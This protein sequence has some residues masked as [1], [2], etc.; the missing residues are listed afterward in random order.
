MRQLLVWS[1]GSPMTWDNHGVLISD[2]EQVVPAAEPYNRLSYT[3]HAITP[4]LAKRFGW[5][6]E[7]LA[8]LSGEARSKVTF[9]IEEAAQVVKLTVVHDGFEPGSSLAE[10]VSYGWPNVVASLKSLPETG[11]PLPDDA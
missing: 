3:W 10:M 8:R 9:T 1:V 6:E 11:E 2:P 7:L 4:E 5:D